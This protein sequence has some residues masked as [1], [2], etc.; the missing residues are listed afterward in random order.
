MASLGQIG[1]TTLGNFILGGGSIDLYFVIKLPTLSD[2]TN[3]YE[4]SVGFGDSQNFSNTSYDNGVFFNYSSTINSGNW[5]GST[6]SATTKSVLNTSTAVTTSWTTLRINVN[7]AA[8]LCTFYV[9]GVSLGTINSNIP[10]TTV[11]PM[12]NIAKSA[13]TGERFLNI[14]L[15]YI[16]Q[17]LTA[18]R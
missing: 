2:G 8:T 14:D 15:V 10:T 1:S 13:S 9:N 12:F 6:S 18:A 5:Q 16:T 11:S 4:I 7:A 3:T 17:A